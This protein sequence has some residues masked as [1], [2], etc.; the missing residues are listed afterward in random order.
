M[1][2][3]NAQTDY[4][5]C[6]ERVEDVYFGKLGYDDARQSCVSKMREELATKVPQVNLMY[7]GY[8]KNY[9]TLDG[10]IIGGINQGKDVKLIEE[11]KA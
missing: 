10:S 8:M 5:S 4:K 7:D 3:S 2:V 6:L 1:I 9:K 11:A